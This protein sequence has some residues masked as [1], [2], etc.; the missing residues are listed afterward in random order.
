MQ[1]GLK[2]ELARVEVD[3]EVKEKALAAELE[4]CH[5]LMLWINEES[6]QQ[7]VRHVAFYHC[8]PV[9]DSHYDLNKDGVNGKLV[10]LGG[11]VDTVMEETEDEPNRIEAIEPEPSFEE[12]LNNFYFSL[13]NLFSCLHSHDSPTDLCLYA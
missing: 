2:A 1:E 8:V 5:E 6:F 13:N 10:P 7:G 3:A 4:K 11:N 12:I 9:D